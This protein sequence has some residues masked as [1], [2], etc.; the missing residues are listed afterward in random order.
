MAIYTPN[1]GS[2]ANSESCSLRVVV[3]GNDLPHE[4]LQSHFRRLSARSKDRNHPLLA[5]FINEA[6]YA[7]K[8]EISTLA[9]DLQRVIPTF[10]TILEWAEDTKLREG[11]LCGA[12]DGVLLVVLQLAS[13]YETL[14]H[15]KEEGV[16]TALTG[17]GLGLLS[18][19]AVSLSPTLAQL[20]LAGADAVRLAL[21]LQ[22][23]VLGISE[24]LEARDAAAKPASWAYVVQN[25]DAASAQQELDTVFGTEKSSGSTKVFISTMNQT[26]VTLSG[27][28]SRLRLFFN[29]S[30]LFR[31]ARFSPLPVYGGL[32]HAPHIYGAKD[33]ESIV[34][35]CGLHTAADNSVPVF[36]I[37]STSTGIPFLTK[38]A[39]ETFSCVVSELLT[40]RVCWDNVIRG[41]GDRID[42]T[43]ASAAAVDHFGNSVC[44]HDLEVALKGILH[45]SQVTLTNMLSASSA[46]PLPREIRPR[47]AGL[48]KLA[49]V[50]MSCRLPGGATD[51]ERFW[52]VLAKGLDVSRRIPADRFD[53]DTHYDATGKQLNKS[54]TQYGCFI[55]EPG[56]FDA[57]FFNMSPR[58]S[59]TTDPQMRLAL[60]TA[61][62]AL[63]QAGFVG[64]RTASTRLERVGTYYG[65]A[66]DDYR[67]VNQGQE[68]G[69]YYIPG[70]CR[71]FG[72]GRIN[73]FFKFAGPS[74]SIDTACSSGLAA[75]E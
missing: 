60:V 2:D 69:T 39:P 11:L 68:V 50:G 46:A 10:Q 20:P 1:K 32:C 72:P 9:T 66:A 28:P 55:D 29:K 13:Y 22:V 51:T 65:Q 16:N 57:P 25:M 21:R 42:C 18:S 73:Y 41:L 15:D 75:I 17:L 43:G 47:R 5:R 63:E 52:D 53:I 19:T 58:E 3:F 24:M 40:R 30:A 59:Q 44:V 33:T 6:T 71:A 62:E 26:S 7:V 8:Q 34:D 37:Y 45:E 36:P 12:V 27:P 56:L 70:G 61:Y 74:Y 14:P 35:G 67:E 54:M 48:S 23:H 38:T 49:I 4:D 31:T 64:N